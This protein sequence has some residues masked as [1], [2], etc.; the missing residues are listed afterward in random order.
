MIIVLTLGRSGS[1]LLMQTL[2]KLG[3]TVAGRQFDVKGDSLSQQ[4]HEALNPKGYFESP[5]IYF[6]GPSSAAFQTLM[7][8]DRRN[9]ACKMD[10]RHFV[11]ERQWP[12]WLDA[13]EAI[14]S[15]LLSYRSPAEQARSEFAGVAGTARYREQS[16][17][18]T[19]ITRFLKDY[20]ETYGAVDSL[21]GS[22]LQPLASKID[23]IA[24]SEAK[25]AESYTV[26]LGALVGLQ[27][28]PEQLSSAVSNI[29]PKLFRIRDSDL[30]PEE[31]HWASQLG[32]TAVYSQLENSRLLKTGSASGEKISENAE[33]P[34]SR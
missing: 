22:T 30:S 2:Q 28:S 25:N 12:Y 5:E 31:R 27:P 8:S 4:F 3:V 20:V 19:F 15:I 23:Y 26:R 32:A 24:Y 14:S 9:M 29:S 18:F 6:G 11:D 1:S 34:G 7:K 16:H 17:E 10:V 33:I 13:A 21:V